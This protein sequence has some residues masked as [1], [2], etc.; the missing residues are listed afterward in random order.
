VYVGAI[1]DQIA[2]EMKAEGGQVTRADLAAYRA[3]L[4]QPTYGVYRGYR[5]L[6]C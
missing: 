2:A 5:G 6:S 4:R 3:K 1:A